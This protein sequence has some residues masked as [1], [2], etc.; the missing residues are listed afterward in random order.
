VRSSAALPGYERLD[1]EIPVV[2]APGMEEPAA[3]L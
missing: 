1:G 3:G 2:H